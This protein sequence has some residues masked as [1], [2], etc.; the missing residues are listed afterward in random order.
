M[1][2][3]FVIG[4]LILSIKFIVLACKATWGMAKALLFI[5][6]LPVILIGLLIA[7]FISLAAPLLIITLIA[8]FIWSF[9]KQYSLLTSPHKPEFSFQNHCYSAF[10]LQESRLLLNQSG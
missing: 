7:G 5:I 1:I 2:T 8:V 9:A 6:G 3:L 10:L 4:I